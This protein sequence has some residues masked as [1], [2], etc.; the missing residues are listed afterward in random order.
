[1]TAEEIYTKIESK[2][3]SREMGIKLIEN[4]GIRQQQYG[5]KKLLEDAP[6]E[7]YLE[8]EKGIKKITE[9]LDQMLENIAEMCTEKDGL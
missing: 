2:S 5:I 7:H 8:I 3:I 9:K 6:H 1:M 4:Y